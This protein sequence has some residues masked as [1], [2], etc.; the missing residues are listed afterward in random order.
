[1]WKDIYDAGF[2][3]FTHVEFGS[4]VL[5]IFNFHCIDKISIRPIDKQLN[6]DIQNS[7]LNTSIND[8]LSTYKQKFGFD[9]SYMKFKVDG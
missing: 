3:G 1:M 8:V 4:K 7:N 2:D 5:S 6:E 9:L